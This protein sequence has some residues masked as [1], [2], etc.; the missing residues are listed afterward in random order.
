MGN[1]QSSPRSGIQS[2]IVHRTAA[3]RP[4]QS[5]HPE[6]GQVKGGPSYFSEL[7]GG[8]AGLMSAL[9]AGVGTSSEENYMASLDAVIRTSNI[10]PW[11]AE[12][13]IREKIDAQ[14]ALLYSTPFYKV[15]VELGLMYFRDNTPHYLSSGLSPETFVQVSKELLRH[16]HQ[17]EPTDEALLDIYDSIDYDLSQRLSV[18]EWAGGL[19]QFFRGTDENKDRAV[20]HLLDTG[21]DGKLDRTE[22]KEY[23]APLIKAMVPTDTAPLR[24]LVLSF[25]SDHIF[26]FIDLN[27]DGYIST[28]E[29]LDWNSKNDIIKLLSQMIEQPVYKVWVRK[30]L[31]YEPLDVSSMNMFSRSVGMPA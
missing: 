23:L 31:G 13:L 11:P 8:D 20:F 6:L 22:L 15:N 7:A 27:K 9:D 28:D 26:R 2:E 16:V 3:R 17:P 14:Q 19:K 1:D 21:G 10:Q 18:G 12:E 24:P 25:L 4:S 30:N 5:S 29:Y